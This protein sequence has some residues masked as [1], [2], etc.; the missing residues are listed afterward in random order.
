MKYTSL[1]T[2]VINILHSSDYNLKLVFYDKD[3]NLTTNTNEVK[4][5]FIKD[6]NFMI[7]LSDN[8]S[9]YIFIWKNKNES[10]KNF[11]RI[12]QQIR[13]LAVL[14]GVSVQIKLYD[15][16]D[17]RMIHNLVKEK[18]KH[19][20][21]VENMS[22]CL[23]S[24]NQ[25]CKNTKRPSDFYMSEDLN[26]ANNQQIVKNIIVEFNNTCDK[27]QLTN[28]HLT[29]ML[30]YSSKDEIMEEFNNI[31]DDMAKLIILENYNILNPISQ[32]VCNKYLKNTNLLQSCEKTNIKFLDNAKLYETVKITNSDNLN[33]AYNH[34]ISVCSEA[35]CGTDI[36]LAI[37]KNRLCETYKVSKSDLL[38]MWLS[39]TTDKEI[40][41]DKLY[42]IET[43]N[44]D[45]YCFEKEMKFGIDSM[46]SHINKGGKPNDDIANG[47]ISETL[48]L[49]SIV[50]FIDKHLNDIN[51]QAYKK[52]IKQLFKETVENIS[53]QSPKILNEEIESYVYERQLVKL[54]NKFGFKHP[55][56]KY[57]AI[58]E[59]KKLD[60]E[61]R[62]Q[63]ILE[64][65]DFATLKCALMDC[66]T[67]IKADRV[68]NSIIKNKIGLTE[69][70]N[71]DGCSYDL[72]KKLYDNVYSVDSETNDIV[73][74]CLFTIINQPKEKLNETKLSFINVLKKYIM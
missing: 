67:R 70:I 60:K 24:V 42:I 29:K 31:N 7:E 45:Q 8:E 47:I 73:N 54:Q 59:Q 69:N 13:E 38:D 12:I 10:P 61:S 44:N 40:K 41:Q 72:A 64:K 4:W 25:Y 33:K 68:A 63:T 56:L 2:D 65:R 5:C 28:K 17:R 66:T 51:V 39:N 18:M 48:K 37:K 43:V 55:A 30:S 57:L 9:P 49:N 21:E 22:E 26:S 27:N 52:E 53:T 1:T 32:F 46:L 74:T 36:L 23:Y 14:N 6:Y 16:L 15:K 50:D 3:G 62:Y 58:N 19:N 35:K 71:V 20:Q 34:L 11:N